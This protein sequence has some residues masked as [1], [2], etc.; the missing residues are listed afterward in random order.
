MGVG[1]DES[2]QSHFAGAIDFNQLLSIF[3][4]PWITP[5][6]ARSADR[7]NLSTDAEDGA[8]F[9]DPKL[10]KFMAA[11]RAGVAGRGTERKQLA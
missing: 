7:D 11:S 1:V 10:V 4:D 2:G 9:N 3:L 6:F 8:I 5:R